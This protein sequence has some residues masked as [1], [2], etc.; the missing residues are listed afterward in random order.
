MKPPAGVGRER[1]REEERGGDA[2][3]G[4]KTLATFYYATYAA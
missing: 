1:R 3:A 2:P 4:G